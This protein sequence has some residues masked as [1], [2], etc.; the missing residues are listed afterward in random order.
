MLKNWL[1]ALMLAGLLYAVNPLVV[2]QDGG[3][4]DA[5][6]APAGAPPEHGPGHGHFDPAKRTEM[7]TKQLN[8]SSDQQAKVQDIL[9]S[10]Q[11]QMQKVHEDSSASQE[12]RRAKMMDLHKSSNEQIRTLLNADQQKK[13]DAMQSRHEQWMQGHRHGQVPGGTPDSSEQK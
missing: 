9:K 1:L 10:E 12:D 7:L 13:W 11:S 8:L 3:G 6:S 2:A 5:Q 4:N